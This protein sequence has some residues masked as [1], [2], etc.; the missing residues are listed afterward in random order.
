[1]EQTT[2]CD[3]WLVSGTEH[4]LPDFHALD[5][6]ALKNSMSTKTKHIRLG[7]YYYL[8]HYD[9]IELF[10]AIPYLSAYSFAVALAV[11][12]SIKSTACQSDI[13]M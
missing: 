6:D 8:K 2:M 3:G 10:R 7:I 13:T 4:H 11:L 9:C 5:G 12:V 1:M